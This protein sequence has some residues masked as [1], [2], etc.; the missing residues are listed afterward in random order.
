MVQTT[1][2]AQSSER[3]A[4]LAAGGG[5]PVD[6][7]GLHNGRVVEERLHGDA[8]R[9]AWHAD[10]DWPRL[11]AAIEGEVQVIVSN[12]AEGGY[13]PDPSD[14]PALLQTVPAGGAA[15]PRGF[16]AKLLVLLH[17][18]WNANP[19][20]PLTLCPCELIAR[21]GDTLRDLVLGLAAAWQVPDAFITWLRGH[22]VWVNS[23]VDRIVA[24]PLHPVGAVAEPYALWAVERQPRMVLPCSHPAIALTDDL[25]RFE[26][27]KLLML[28]LGHSYLAE[29]WLAHARPPKETVYEAMN[30]PALRRQLEA[31][32]CDEVL[33]VFEALGEGDAAR[34]YLATLRDR[35]LNP[36]L[37]HRLSDIARDHA[38]KKRRRIVPLLVLAEEC[39]L[40]YGQPLLRAAMATA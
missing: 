40:A 32:W 1:A 2:S 16:P 4:A 26:R 21:N 14:G 11:L 28:N 29:Q 9:A 38:L 34:A 35:L 20:A 39:G 24:E 15:A 30:D 18:R 6:V 25:G 17:H 3:L 12:T 7:R 31:V 22:C 8:I 36:F 27:L 13:A 19:A 37:K 33:P 10:R 23:L 5:Y